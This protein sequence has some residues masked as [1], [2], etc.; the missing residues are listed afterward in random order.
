MEINNKYTPQSFTALKFKQNIVQD[1]PAILKQHDEILRFGVGTNDVFVS[2]YGTILPEKML[3]K[4]RQ[5]QEQ[6]NLVNIVLGY[7]KFGKNIFSEPVAGI[8]IESNNK[9]VFKQPLNTNI[10][11]IN[12]RSNDLSKENSFVSE[13][14]SCLYEQIANAE[15]I[16]K[17]ITPQ[18]IGNTK[19]FGEL[20]IEGNVHNRIITMIEHSPLIKKLRSLHN[21]TIESDFKSVVNQANHNDRTYQ[22]EINIYW[23]DKENPY[24]IIGSGVSMKLADDDAIKKLLQI[25]F[26]QVQKEVAK[27]AHLDITK[28]TIFK[29]KPSFFENFL[30]IFK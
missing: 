17:K 12:T 19:P 10:E 9:V 3:E 26:E 7:F 25:P 11:R 21:I 20:T 30:E 8:A 22:R 13:V 23:S 2:R 18:P 1:L 28:P 5:N 27:T 29:E 14:R 24:S 16:V 4:V 6:N 15:D